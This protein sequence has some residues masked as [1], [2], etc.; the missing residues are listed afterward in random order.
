MCGKSIGVFKTYTMCGKPFTKNG[1]DLIGMD[2]MKVVGMIS[3]SLQA[4]LDHPQVTEVRLKA[5]EVYLFYFSL[6]NL[7]FFF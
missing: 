3:R 1:N 7:L 4:F 6:L 5:I 2:K